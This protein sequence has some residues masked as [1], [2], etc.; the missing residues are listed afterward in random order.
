MEQT[1]RQALTP[2]LTEELLD[3]LLFSTDVKSFLDSHDLPGIT[4][5]SYLDELLTQKELKKNEVIRQ[6]GIN[7]TFGYDIFA[8]RTHPSRNYVLQLTFAL[9]CTFDE[10]Q[11][12]LKLAD[13]GE[14]YPKIRRDAIV[15]FCIEHGQNL[16]DTDSTLYKFGEQTITKE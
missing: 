11:R 13:V 5:Q 16:F 15:I 7:E 14:L 10:T 2:V 8:G 9:N 4:L 6:S 12:V 3:E 1:S